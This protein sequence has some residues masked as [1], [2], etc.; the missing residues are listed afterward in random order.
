MIIVTANWPI[1]SNYRKDLD[2]PAYYYGTRNK[3]SF[4]CEAPEELQGACRVEDARPLLV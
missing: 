4:R 2:S 1:L 3:R